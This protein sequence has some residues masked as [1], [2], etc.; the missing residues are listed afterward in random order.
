MQTIASGAAVDSGSREADARSH[1][2]ET[3]RHSEQ[4]HDICADPK[5]TLAN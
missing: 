2:C 5:Q 4:A 1:E 3:G